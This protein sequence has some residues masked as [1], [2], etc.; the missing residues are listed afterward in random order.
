VA[1]EDWVHN[2]NVTAALHAGVPGQETGNAVVDVLFS[3]SPQVTNPSRR[4]PYTISKARE[5]SP[6]DVLYTSIDGTP[7]ITYKEE[8]GIDGRCVYFSVSSAMLTESHSTGGSISR[9][10]PHGSS[11]DSG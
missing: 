3:D 2:P 7:Q 4:L 6:A 1:V 11:S 5:D 8:L 9:I 10:S